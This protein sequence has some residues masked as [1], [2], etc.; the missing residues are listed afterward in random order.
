MVEKTPAQKFRFYEN[1][2]VLFWLIKD[3]CWC[4]LYKP[5]ALSMIAPTLILAIYFT[6]KFRKDNM[7][8]AHNI[9][10]CAWISANSIWMIGEF[11]YD[12]G[13][14]AY[15]ASFFGLGLITLTIY[16][17]GVLPYTKWKLKQNDLPN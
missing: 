14:R 1:L 2:H 8:L 15:A 5:I 9:A 4:M 3:M 7:E 17:L 16:Y 12:D 10:I 6:I 13:L 11:Y